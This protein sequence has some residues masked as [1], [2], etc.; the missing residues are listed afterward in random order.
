M[1]IPYTFEIDAPSYWAS[2]LI[3][4]DASSL[5]PE[6]L[7]LIHAWLA[8]QGGYVLTISDETH[9]GQWTP[10]KPFHLSPI[11]SDLATYTLAKHS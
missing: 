8:E 7:D 5:T 2:Y 10:P 6:M 1:V 9:I 4:G 3:N 11:L